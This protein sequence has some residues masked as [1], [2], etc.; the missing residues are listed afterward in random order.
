[1]ARVPV[2]RG[3]HECRR[4]IRDPPATDA[5][6]PGIHCRAAGALANSG[7][8]GS[9]NRSTDGGPDIGPDVGPT[10]G[11]LATNRRP[12]GDRSARRPR[13]D[14]DGDPTDAG[15]DSRPAD[16]DTPPPADGDT[17][18]GA[19]GNTATGDGAAARTDIAP[20]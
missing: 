5:Q 14:R 2:T 15:T 16:P 10:G 17:R 19:D 18:P 6:C 1:M 8:D 12:S 11:C 7:A 4:G 3:W 20:D 13:P 9:T